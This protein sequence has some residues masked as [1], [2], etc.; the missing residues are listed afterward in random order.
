MMFANVM[1]LP[2]LQLAAH[3][4]KQLE[5]LKTPHPVTICVSACIHNGEEA[6][7]KDIGLIGIDR[8]WEIHVGGQGGRDVRVGELLYVAE[9]SE[10]AI[11]MVTALIQY[12]RETAS[13]LER[14]GQWVDRIGLIHIREVLFERDLRSQLNKRLEEDVMKYKEIFKRSFLSQEV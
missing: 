7:T 5:F 11:E 2:S 8:G 6:M 12:Y 1:K 9:T 4:D 3:L 13:Y 14:T 10:V